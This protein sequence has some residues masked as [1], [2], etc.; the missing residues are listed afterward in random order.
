MYD[1]VYEKETKTE[2]CQECNGTGTIHMSCCGDNITNNI[3]ETDLCPTCYEHCGDEGEECEECNGTG[4]VDA[5]YTPD[6]DKDR[7]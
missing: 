5:S 2:D 3:E 6:P 7:L 4:E 1:P